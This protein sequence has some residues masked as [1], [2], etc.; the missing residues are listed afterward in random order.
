M[1]DFTISTY[2]RT[3]HKY[4]ERHW[5]FRRWSRQYK[6][7]MALMKGRKI[8]DAGCGPGRDSK[9]FLSKGY[10]VLGTDKSKGMIEEAKIRV[11]EGRFRKADLLRLKLKRHSF[12]GIWC[13]AS[14]LHIKKTAA[15]R[16]IS[17][18][19]RILKSGGVLFM[20]LKMGCGERIIM[21]P[22]GSRRFF[23]FYDAKELENIV[24]AKFRIVKMYAD[25]DDDGDTWLSVFASND[26]Q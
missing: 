17:S 10:A 25:T 20:S 24:G 7:F 9:Y 1:R 12:D 8:L 2:D 3:A 11:P 5:D 4:A 15:P 21:Y 26:L 14:L 22:D 6:D 13:C 23:S 16:I 19:Q 18:F